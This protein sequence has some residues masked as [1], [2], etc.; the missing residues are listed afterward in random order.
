MHPQL[1]EDL[2]QVVGVPYRTNNEAFDT[3]VTCIKDRFEQ[4]GFGVYNNLERLLINTCTGADYES[5]LAICTDFELHN[6]CT[7]LQILRDKFCDERTDSSSVKL[8]DVVEF[9]VHLGD[10]NLRL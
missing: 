2:Y 4:P 9:V 6:L 1:K 10:A 7:Q 3:I 5:E 8:S